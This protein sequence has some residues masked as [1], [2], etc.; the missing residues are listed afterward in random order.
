MIVMRYVPRYYCMIAS[1]L[2]F[3]P[4]CR[5]IASSCAYLQYRG[6]ICS[7]PTTSSCHVHSPSTVFNEEISSETTISKRDETSSSSSSSI[8]GNISPAMMM[9]IPNQ[10]LEM[11]RK[12]EIPI[13]AIPAA[14]STEMVDRIRLD[15]SALEKLGSGVK[16]AGVGTT[17]LSQEIRKNVHQVWLSTPGELLNMDGLPFVGDLDIRQTL[18]DIV[19][20]MR[21]DLVHGGDDHYL[22][23]KDL[24]EEG[25]MQKYY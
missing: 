21:L 14:I 13:L 15:S 5:G 8:S 4:R 10:S 9:M 19:E 2:T 24:S 3:L 6:K 25:K 7:T 1:S 20:R 18:F 23:S 11:F 17:G 22:L 12:G 16:S